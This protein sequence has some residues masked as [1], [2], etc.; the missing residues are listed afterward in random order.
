MTTIDLMTLDECLWAR[1]KEESILDKMLAQIPQVSMNI[2]LEQERK[3]DSLDFW[4]ER[5]RTL[6]NA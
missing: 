4:I 2:L 5:K 3:L 1:A 6:E